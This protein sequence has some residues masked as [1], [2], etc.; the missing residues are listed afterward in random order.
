MAASLTSSSWR[1][2][3]ELCSWAVSGAVSF[4]VVCR[5]VATAVRPLR[6]YACD[7]SISAVACS[8]AVWCSSFELLAL[9]LVGLEM[10][11]SAAAGVLALFLVALHSCEVVCL[12]YNKWKGH[13]SRLRQLTSCT[14]SRV[15]VWCTGVVWALRRVRADAELWFGVVSLCWCC[16]GVGEVRNSNDDIVMTLQWLVGGCGQSL[17]FCCGCPVVVS[18][19][20]CGTVRMLDRYCRRWNSV[21]SCG[22]V[23][24]WRLLR[25]RSRCLAERC[26]VG[27]ASARVCVGQCIAVFACVAWSWAGGADTGRAAVLVDHCRRA[28]S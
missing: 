22:S 24:Q 28:T 13:L 23:N 1:W 10:G 14:R 11:V 25:V 18:G 21:V 16:S 2:V 19:A 8:V 12:L 17:N 15:A 9:T 5:P 6:Y 3:S 4:A 27:G 26:V 20:S 7:G